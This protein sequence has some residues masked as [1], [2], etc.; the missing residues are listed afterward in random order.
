VPLAQQAQFLSYRGGGISHP[1]DRALQFIFGDA[2]MPGPILH[3]MRLAHGDMAS[4]AAAFVKQMITHCRCHVCSPSDK[5]DP[6]WGKLGE[7][8]RCLAAWRGW[9]N[10][11]L[12]LSA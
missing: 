7:A 8:F 12:S 4:V 6:A 1:L 9:P 5:K 2:K 11:I 3:L 10:S